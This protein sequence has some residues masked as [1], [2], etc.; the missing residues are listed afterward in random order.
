MFAVL[1][2]AVALVAFAAVT[3]LASAVLAVAW[4]AVDVDR[5]PGLGGGAGPPPVRPARAAGGRWR[6]WRRAR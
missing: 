5:G 1:G 3:V 2:L 4:P 6:R